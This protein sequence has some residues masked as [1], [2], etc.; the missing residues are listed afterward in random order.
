MLGI[1]KRGWLTVYNTEEMQAEDQPQQS[2]A[3]QTP[4]GFIRDRR[5]RDRQPQRGPA[6]VCPRSGVQYACPAGVASAAVCSSAHGSGESGGESG[7]ALRSRVPA[8]RGLHLRGL[9]L[10]EIPQ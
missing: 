2:E 1:D 7:E 5:A 3:V 8:G 10:E 4:A 6:A 9:P